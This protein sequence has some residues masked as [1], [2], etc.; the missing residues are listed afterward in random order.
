M[1]SIT[2]SRN[3]LE[4][5]IYC[6]LSVNAPVSDDMLQSAPSLG[7]LAESTHDD[8]DLDRLSIVYVGFIMNDA[9]QLYEDA[10]AEMYARTFG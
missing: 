1:L 2:R 4:F 9:R 3:G 8:L 5:L 6:M 10:D 7:Q